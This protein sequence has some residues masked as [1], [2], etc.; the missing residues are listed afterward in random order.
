MPPRGGSGLTLF[1]DEA[2]RLELLNRCFRVTWEEEDVPVE[3]S[4]GDGGLVVS[5]IQLKKRRGNA[6]RREQIKKGFMAT[7]SSPVTRIVRATEVEE[8]C[9][10][11]EAA[12]NR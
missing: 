3:I 5:K 10:H 12:M 6:G 7:A 2:L 4:H 8:S 11:G 1:K 9:D